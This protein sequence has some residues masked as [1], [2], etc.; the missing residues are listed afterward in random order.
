M[1]MKGLTLYHL[2]SH[3][4]KY[5]LGKQ[6]R[7]ETGLLD[8]NKNGSSSGVNYSSA[9]NSDV[10]RGNNGGEMPLAESLR[11]Q[12]EVQRKL[13]E[14]LEVQKKLQMRIEAQ[15]KYLQ[16]ILE[17]AQKSLSYDVNDTEN[18]EESR[19]QLTDF[20]LNLSGLMENVSNIVSEDNKK[21][22]S[23][24]AKAH[25]SGFRLYQEDTEDTADVK[26]PSGGG[27][28]HL[29]LNM[30]GGGYDLFGGTLGSELDLRMQLQGR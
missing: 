22:E 26:F 14:Q 15:G 1:G 7:K 29:D 4:Q 8:A 25:V 30:K 10:S 6:A 5:R 20:N 3:L 12:I 27:S 11:Y 19:A 9:T 16:A 18:I 24:K 13:Q 21:T 23:G 17:K 28:Q 2:K